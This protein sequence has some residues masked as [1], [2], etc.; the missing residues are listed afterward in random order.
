AGSLQLWDVATQQPLGSPLTTP[1]EEIDSLSFSS[2]G[3]TVYASS[4]HMP[5]QRYVVDP[6]RAQTLVCAR[7]GGVGLTPAQWH[8]YVPEVPYLRLCDATVSGG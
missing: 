6:A 1:G 3:T 8:T 2:D 5:L 7:A 4:A